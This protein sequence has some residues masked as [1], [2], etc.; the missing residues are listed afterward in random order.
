METDQTKERATS[1]KRSIHPARDCSSALTGNPIHIIMG[2]KME[3][4][5]YVDPSAELRQ[6]C[7]S[8][9]IMKRAVALFDG[10][11][12]I[13]KQCNNVFLLPSVRWDCVSA[14][15]DRPSILTTRLKSTKQKKHKLFSE[16]VH[17]VLWSE[18]GRTDIVH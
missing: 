1:G 14:E 16:I 5:V 6:L 4:T 9:H 10:K 12:A 11:E 8:T 7:R 3:T 17:Q 2:K 13:Q 15:T 18:I